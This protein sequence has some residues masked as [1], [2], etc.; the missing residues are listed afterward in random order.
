MRTFSVAEQSTRYCDFNK[1]KFGGELTFIKPAWWRKPINDIFETGEAVLQDC[2]ETIE[3]SCQL[4]RRLGWKP[5]QARQVLPLGL[6]TQ[7]V[8]TAF[9]DD[10]KHFLLLRSSNAVSGK[11]HPNMVVIADKIAEIA[12]EQKLW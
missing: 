11:A 12:K 9:E 4:L 8:Y 6:K 1:Y 7:A 2:Y 10:W 3:D 5:E